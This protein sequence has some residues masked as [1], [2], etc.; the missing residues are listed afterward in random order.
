MKWHLFLVSKKLDPREVWAFSCWARCPKKDCFWSSEKRW[1]VAET[2]GR[3]TPDGK[4]IAN[5]TDLAGYLLEA[6]GVAIV[7]GAAFG[8]EP[9]FRISYATSTDT[10]T[11]ACERIQRACGALS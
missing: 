11:D 10:L 2:I 6:E 4:V 9:Y 8:L 1:R 5:D 7:Q 3:T